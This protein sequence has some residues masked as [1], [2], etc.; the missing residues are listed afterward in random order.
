MNNRKN[1]FE[2]ATCKSKSLM[3]AQE[4]VIYTMVA[5]MKSMGSSNQGKRWLECS[6][7]GSKQKYPFSGSKHGKC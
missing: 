4:M 5:S 3:I 6:K 2:C 7:C 1:R